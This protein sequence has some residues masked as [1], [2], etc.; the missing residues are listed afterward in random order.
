MNFANNPFLDTSNVGWSRDFGR[1]TAFEPSVCKPGTCQSSKAVMFMIGTYRPAD[2]VGQLFSLQIARPVL[3]STSW[4][5]WI[6]PV[7]RRFISTT[8]ACQLSWM[9]GRS[10]ILTL[11]CQP[12]PQLHILWL[13]SQCQEIP[14]NRAFGIFLIEEP[15][16]LA[17]AI[18]AVHTQG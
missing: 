1:A 7:R 8:T 16:R 9:K 13:C 4:I 6:M 18:S 14:L 2:M 17:I 11:V 15:F 3:V 5:T 10:G 12:L